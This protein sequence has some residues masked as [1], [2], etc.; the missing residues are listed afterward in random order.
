[1]RL[2]TIRTAAGTRAVRIDG[3][4]AVETGHSD[5][6]DRGPRTVPEHLCRREMTAPR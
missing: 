2:A 6:L 4:Q 3:D 5:H 1:M